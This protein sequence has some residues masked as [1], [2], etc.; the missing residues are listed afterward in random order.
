M[1]DGSVMWNV[2]AYHINVWSVARAAAE[3]DA[4]FG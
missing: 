4:D 1:R 3:Q 2:Q